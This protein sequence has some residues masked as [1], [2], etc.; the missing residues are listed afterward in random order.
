[1]R[2]CATPPTS[3]VLLTLLAAKA[4][5]LLTGDK[6]L[7]AASTPSSRLRNFGHATESDWMLQENRPLG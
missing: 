3:L 1:M 2:T 7:L 6:E 4:D 5:Y